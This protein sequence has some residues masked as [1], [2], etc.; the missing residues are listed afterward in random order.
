VDGH[1][2]QAFKVHEVRCWAGRAVKVYEAA[3]RDEAEKAAKK[4]KRDLDPNWNAGTYYYATVHD[5]SET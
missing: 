4:A 1:K 5:P 2:Q 3:A